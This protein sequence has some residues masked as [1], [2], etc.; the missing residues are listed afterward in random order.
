MPY[1]IL[2]AIS[3]RTRCSCSKNSNARFEVWTHLFSLHFQCGC[4]NSV[5]S[6]Q[7]PCWGTKSL[8]T[9]WHI[10]DPSRSREF[11]LC[12]HPTWMGRKPY[13]GTRSQDLVILFMRNRVH[14]IMQLLSW[15]KNNT[16]FLNI[17][18]FLQ[19]KKVWRF[20]YQNC[21]FKSSLCSFMFPV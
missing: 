2:S 11:V 17:H 19:H 7:R 6:V 12:L 1:P 8:P 13:G 18:N 14:V 3:C 21:W 10:W 5:T 15:S 20:D 16:F 4:F 9:P